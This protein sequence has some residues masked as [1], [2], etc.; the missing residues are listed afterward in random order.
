MCAEDVN[1]DD[2]ATDF[3]SKYYVRTIVSGAGALANVSKAFAKNNISIQSVLQKEG[4]DGMAQIVL[5]TAQ[6]KESAIKN[7]LS[8]VENLAC[9]EKIAA[10]IR[11]EE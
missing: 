11:V 4:K 10:V 1:D 8:I 7:T 5:V 3:A 2:F 6:T 9:V